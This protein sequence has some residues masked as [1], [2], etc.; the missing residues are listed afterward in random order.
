M[1]DLIGGC[2]QTLVP[3]PNGRGYVCPNCDGPVAA[4]IDKKKKG[5]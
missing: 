1:G 2:R 3:I 4:A 5:K